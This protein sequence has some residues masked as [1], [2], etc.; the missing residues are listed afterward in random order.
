MV[1]HS[2]MMLWSP[3]TTLVSLPRVADV[4]RL[5]ADDGV[6]IDVVVA[7]D[8]DVAH[9]GDVVFQP[10]A[11][12]D[13]H[14]RPDDAEGADFDFVVDFGAGVDR[15]IFGKVTGHGRDSFTVGD[16][17]RNVSVLFAFPPG[18]GSRE[19]IPH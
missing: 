1:T 8:G 11:A 14:L 5:A 13:A 9:Q 19:P 12:A 18:P 6:G 7:A 16:F 15:G 10:R 4:L 2:R 3:M 17:R